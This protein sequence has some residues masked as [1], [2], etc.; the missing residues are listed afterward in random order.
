MKLNELTGIKNKTFNVSKSL[1]EIGFKFIGEGLSGQVYEHPNKPYVLK[2]FRNTDYAYRN[3]I[4]FALNNNS[5][6]LPKFGKIFHLDEYSDLVQMEKLQLNNPNKKEI[7]KELD[8]FIN[9]FIDIKKHDQKVQDVFDNYPEQESEEFQKYYDFYYFVYQIM[10]NLKTYRLD[11][12]DENIMFR[13]DTPVI[14][15]PYWM[16]KNSLPMNLIKSGKKL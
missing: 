9:Y 13:N 8:S 1:K 4:N 7:L 16:G 2:I 6:Y 12:H 10:L 3:F 11:L 15:D 14:I 5:I